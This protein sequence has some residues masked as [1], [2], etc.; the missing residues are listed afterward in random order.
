MNKDSK[1]YVAG[2]G[3][4]VGAAIVRRLKAMGYDNLIL[5]SHAEL[6]LTRQVAPLSP[7]LKNSGL[8]LCLWRLRR[9]ARN[10]G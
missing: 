9:S 8:I 6:D 2:H 3:G 7:F 10:F 4:L 1:I 5:R